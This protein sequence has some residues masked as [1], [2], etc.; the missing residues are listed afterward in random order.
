MTT[1][2]VDAIDKVDLE[3]EVPRNQVWPARAPVMEEMF[4]MVFGSRQ[5][6]GLEVG[7]WFGIGSTQ[8]WLS[9]LQ[10]GSEFYLVDAWRPYSSEADFEDTGFNYRKVDALMDEAYMSAYAQVRRFEANPA[11]RDTKLHLVRGDSAAFMAA[12]VD[13]S[14]D[15][16][17]IDGDHKYE[18]VKSDLQQARRLVRKR[19][20]SVICG[21]DL[22]QVPSPELYEEA[23]GHLD[24]DFL[25]EAGYHPGVLAALMEEF[26][27][28]QMCNGFWWVCFVD[29]RIDHQLIQSL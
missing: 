29:G 8:I 26:P 12:L 27:G 3:E 4:R 17:Y 16:I 9:N 25:R 23:R 1:K 10:P 7:V 11:N 13:D 24:Q 18:K 22:D 28:V 5:I 14:F 2:E 6:R 21:D 19:G 15:F 20:I